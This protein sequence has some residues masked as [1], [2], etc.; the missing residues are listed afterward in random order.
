MLPSFEERSVWVQLAS[1]VIVLCAYAGISGAMLSSGVMELPPYVVVF[2]V[3]TILLVIVLVVGHALAAMM[4]RPERR[5]ERDRLIGWRAESNAAWLLA[6]GTFAAIT[7]LSF[8]IP[9]V[10][11]AHLLMLSV[12]AAEILKLT[13]QIIYYRRMS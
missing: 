13:L 7:A 6:A 3:A 10:W 9:S 12:F 4:G 5:D 2:A 8:S 11:V 1:L